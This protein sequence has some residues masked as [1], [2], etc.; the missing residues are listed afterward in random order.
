M[1]RQKE[2]CE[3]STLECTSASDRDG[4]T[5]AIRRCSQLSRRARAASTFGRKDPRHL[6][7]GT[8]SGAEPPR[9]TLVEWLTARRRFIV[10][11]LPPVAVPL[12]KP[13]RDQREPC[14]PL[15]SLTSVSR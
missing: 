8:R 7:P 9:L 6:R 13:R 11:P 2:T 1:R 12:R 5:L 3:I 4:S 15:L 10:T 14:P